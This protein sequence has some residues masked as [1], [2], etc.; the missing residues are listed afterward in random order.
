[1]PWEIVGALDDSLTSDTNK[2]YIEHHGKGNL[3]LEI[4]TSEPNE[5]VQP[6]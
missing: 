1:M 4:R 5:Q 3:Q 6:L 2:D